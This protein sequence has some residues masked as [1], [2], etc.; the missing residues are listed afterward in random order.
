MSC[1]TFIIRGIISKVKGQSIG[2]EPT[3]E[4]RFNDDSVRK[5]NA[6][7]Y[8]ALEQSQE[9]NQE[10]IK[11]KIVALKKSDLDNIKTDESMTTI[12]SQLFIEQKSALF[13]LAYSEKEKDEG[14]ELK[15]LRLY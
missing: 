5:N 14:Y 9:T 13:E 4:Y 12:I 11:E 6:S 15:S 1:S 3:K 8:F 7:L 10:E 2:I